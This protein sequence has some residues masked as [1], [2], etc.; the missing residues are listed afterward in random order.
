MAAFTGGEK[1][2]FPS[3]NPAGD[4]Q[5]VLFGNPSETPK[6]RYRKWI[7]TGC[8][9]DRNC[10]HFRH[11]LQESSSSASFCLERCWVAPPP[12]PCGHIGVYLF[13]CPVLLSFL[14]TRF[15]SIALCWSIGCCVLP[16]ID[17]YVGGE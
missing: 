10:R 9:Q 8:R 5:G 11:I 13:F 15:H 12:L 4:G 3:G 6:V 17:V 2:T 16:G 1:V 14:Q 7:Q